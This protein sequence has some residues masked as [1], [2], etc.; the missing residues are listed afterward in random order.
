MKA[1]D[2]IQGAWDGVALQCMQNVI[3]YKEG[4]YWNAPAS[5]I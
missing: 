4:H 1:T 5:W 2:I 3:I